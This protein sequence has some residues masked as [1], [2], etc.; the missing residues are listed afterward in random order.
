MRERS[1]PGAEA[2][3]RTNIG[4]DPV[5]PHHPGDAAVKAAPPQT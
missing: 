4:L 2:G 1:F 3:V 5:R